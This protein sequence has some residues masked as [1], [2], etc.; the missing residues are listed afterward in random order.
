VELATGA[1]NFSRCSACKEA[2]RFNPRAFD[3]LGRHSAMVQVHTAVRTGR[4]ARA[5]LFRCADCP[6]QATEYEHRDYNRPL[7]VVPICRSCNLR[8]GPAI[9]LNGSL[10]ALVKRGHPPY[11][12]RAAAERV[13]ALI[14][15]DV[16]ALAPYPHTLTVDHWRELLPLIPVVPLRTGCPEASAAIPSPAPAGVTHAAPA[17]QISARSPS[18]P[19]PP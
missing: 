5:S 8:R 2:G 16:T 14:G 11:R 18:T 7:D 6:K 1:G 9:P 10:H 3:W 4:L 12:S 17:A 13:F 15:A 19:P